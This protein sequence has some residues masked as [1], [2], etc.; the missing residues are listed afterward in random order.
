[1]VPAG[2]GWPP[3]AVPV[4][5]RWHLQLSS[6]AE[7]FL[8]GNQTRLAPSAPFLGWSDSFLASTS[9]PQQSLAGH[10]LFPNLDSWLVLHRGL[11]ASL[12]PMLHTHCGFSGILS[13]HK[14][15]PSCTCTESG[16]ERRK[17]SLLRRSVQWRVERLHC[18]KATL[19]IQ[20]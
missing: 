3:T 8:E 17:C 19:A 14:Q 12:A 13:A 1:M 7:K 15:E 20:F 2:E 5:R 6:R 11:S 16:S 9:G 4:L 18:C 10:R